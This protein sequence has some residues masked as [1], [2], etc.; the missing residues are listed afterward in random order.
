MASRNASRRSS[1]GVRLAAWETTAIPESRTWRTK[2]FRG[3][4]A[5]YPGI[6]SSL[7]IVPPVW[8]CPRPLIVATRTPRDAASG[9]ATRVTGSPTPPVE[10][11]SPV[12]ASDASSRRCPEAIS[13]RVRPSTPGRGR[14]LRHAT[15][16]QAAICASSAVPSSHEP[17][18]DS[19]LA[20]STGSPR[21]LRSITSRGA[22]D[23]TMRP[24]T[25]LRGA[26]VAVTAWD[27]AR[28]P[29]W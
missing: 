24:G 9:A 20:A 15:M 13:A 16:H 19:T 21:R 10:C 17:T 25:L 27:G 1:P 7:S 28:G 22:R 5:S 8:A 23:A 3:R 12:G 2:R 4:S 26:S 6:A 18:K 14:P 29:R 11:M